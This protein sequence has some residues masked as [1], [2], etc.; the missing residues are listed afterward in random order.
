MFE[1]ITVATR[2]G[3]HGEHVE[4]EQIRR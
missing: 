2:S 3:G 1:R 4:P